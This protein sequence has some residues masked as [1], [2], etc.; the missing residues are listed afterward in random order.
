MFPSDIAQYPL[1]VPHCMQCYYYEGVHT[2]IMDQFIHIDVS[3]CHHIEL[4]LYLLLFLALQS[5]S[6]IYMHIYVLH[7]MHTKYNNMHIYKVQ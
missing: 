5:T 6:H 7:H 3:I 2:Y 4:H 1:W